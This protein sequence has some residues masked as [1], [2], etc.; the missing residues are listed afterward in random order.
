[1]Q[2]ELTNTLPASVPLE[3]PDMSVIGRALNASR[4]AD[5]LVVDSQPMYAI[6]ATD[7]QTIK[8]ISKQ[9][10][11]ARTALKKPILDAGRAVDA[12]FKAPLDW[13]ATAETSIKR[14]MLAFKQDMDRKAAVE[15][16]ARDKVAREERERLEADA[17]AAAADGKVEEA[18]AIRATADVISA[19]V[20]SI[21]QTKASGIS[22]TK[23]WKARVIDQAALLAHIAAHPE[24][25]EWVTINEGAINRYVTATS[26]RVPIPGCVLGQEEGISARAA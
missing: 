3:A 26:G 20:V 19:P 13:L 23:R 4:A 18:E 14:S 22:T 12:F 15:Q 17:R 5:G 10:E 9:V 21:G 25:I 16:A 2:S 1:M 24:C 11:E 7:L 6:A 8:T